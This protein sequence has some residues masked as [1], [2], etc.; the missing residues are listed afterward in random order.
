MVYS[1]TTGG[2]ARM[3]EVLD[4]GPGRGR[5]PRSAV[6]THRF[7][8]VR[9]RENGPNSVLVKSI[10]FQSYPDQVALLTARGEVIREY[11]HSGHMQRMEVA[12]GDGDGVK[13]I[14]LAGI[15]NGYKTATL[16]VLEPERFAGA[17]VEEAVDYQLQ[18]FAAG[19]ERARILLPRS[20]FNRRLH[21]WNSVEDLWVQ[22]GEISVTVS[23]RKAPRA[24]SVL[25]RFTGEL[26]LK[27]VILSSNFR[28]QHAELEAAGVLD[29]RFTAA[30]EGELHKVR[31]LT[32]GPAQQVAAGG[33]HR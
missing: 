14:Y 13:E 26:K 2:A 3:A 1:S 18:G 25:Y 20:C 12:D 22:P 8:V 5:A 28:A 17:S 24:A 23:E 19:R 4:R 29:H 15:S 32:P 9:L 7:A 33:G 16:V 10:S 27:E 30:E 21:E 11:W 6:H 31:Y